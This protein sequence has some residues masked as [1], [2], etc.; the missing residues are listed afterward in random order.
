MQYLLVLIGL[1][2]LLPATFSNPLPETGMSPVPRQIQ[3]HDP[4]Q[5]CCKANC[6]IENVGDGNM[7]VDWLHTQVTQPIAC[8]G[9]TCSASYTHTYSIGWTVNAGISVGFFNGGFAVSQTWSDERGY[10]CDGNPGETVCVWILVGHA[11][12]TVQPN[13]R[14]YPPICNWNG[15]LLV[16]SPLTNNPGGGFYC[17]RGSACRSINDNYWC[18]GQ[19]EC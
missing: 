15:R 12:Y 14:G 9:G 18:L 13:T 6:H 10:I 7:H 5:E 17:V 4:S 3:L 1:L 19:K 11:A 2:G 16:R 8:N